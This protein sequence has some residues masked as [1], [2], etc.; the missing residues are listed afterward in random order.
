[1]LVSFDVSGNTLLHDATLDAP[2]RDVPRGAYVTAFDALAFFDNIAGRVPLVLA[3]QA[4]GGQIRLALVPVFWFPNSA[5]I[6]RL[7]TPLRLLPRG[8]KTYC[9]VGFE[10]HFFHQ[11]LVTMIE[12]HI[13]VSV[14]QPSSRDP[15]WASAISLPVYTVRSSRS[16]HS[17]C[18]T[19]A[20]YTPI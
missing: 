8:S 2:L 14:V 12:E 10:F 11:R 3:G 6:Q 16:M 19:P 9:H 18:E 17:L 1:M 20:A 5:R 15:A 4:H 13:E 7:K